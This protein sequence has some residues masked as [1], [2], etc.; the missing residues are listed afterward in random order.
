VQVRCAVLNGLDVRTFKR[1]HPLD[2]R[3]VDL[4]EAM[5]A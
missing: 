2:R 1:W 5:A 4:P 3:L